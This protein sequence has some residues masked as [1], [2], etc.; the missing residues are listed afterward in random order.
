MFAEWN[1][2]QKL[3]E[4]SPRNTGGVDFAEGF[5]AFL[6]K[7][8]KKTPVVCSELSMCAYDGE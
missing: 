2:V 3:T 1:G 6:P 8:T 7:M 4:S 5:K